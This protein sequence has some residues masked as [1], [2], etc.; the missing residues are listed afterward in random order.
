M[1]TF[2]F[3]YHLVSH[4]Y[5]KGDAFQF[6]RGYQFSAVP[7]LPQQR[8][9]R[10]TFK[11]MVYYLKADGTIDDTTNAELNM[12][13]MI[14]FYE[15]HRGVDFIYPHPAYGNLTVQFAVGQT[16]ETPKPLEGGNGV[17]D[18]FEVFVIEQ[19]T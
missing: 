6:G 3:P 4:T 5:P 15:A 12:Q 13:T 11:A 17:T 7:Q 18:G 2:N 14:E 10:L 16:F 8:T 1:D 9:F 19:L